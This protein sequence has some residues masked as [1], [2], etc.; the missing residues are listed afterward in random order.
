MS[1]Y[2]VSDRHDR[3]GHGQMLL[4]RSPALYILLVADGLVEPRRL[5]MFVAEDTP[6]KHTKAKP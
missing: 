3:I 1:D 2:S 5:G 4:L 6:A